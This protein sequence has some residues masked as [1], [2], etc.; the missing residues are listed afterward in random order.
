MPFSKKYF[1]KL[2]QWTVKKYKVFFGKIN[3]IKKIKKITMKCRNNIIKKTKARKNFIIFFILYILRN[4]T[5]ETVLWYNALRNY[6]K[7]YIDKK[8]KI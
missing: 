1:L 5:Q 4:F 3:K 8:Y 2:W 7:I 6:R